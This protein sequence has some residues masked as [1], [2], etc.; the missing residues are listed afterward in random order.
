MG[1]MWGGNGLLK[2][3]Y[4]SPAAAAILWEYD[5]ISAFIFSALAPLK[6]LGD[7][8]R[9]GVSFFY[10]G[11]RNNSRNTGKFQRSRRCLMLPWIGL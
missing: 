7:G 11:R 9:G 3:N 4:V 8:G 1:W 2:I 6:T 5:S 10:W